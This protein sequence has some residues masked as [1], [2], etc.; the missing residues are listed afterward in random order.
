MTRSPTIDDLILVVFLLALVGASL[1]AF[2]GQAQACQARGGVLLK[3]PF[4][5][6]CSADFRDRP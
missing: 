5:Y 6:V 2:S 1:L 4:G 3:G